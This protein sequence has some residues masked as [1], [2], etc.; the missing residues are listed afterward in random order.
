MCMGKCA[1][2]VRIGTLSTLPRLRQ[3]LDDRRL[4]RV[5]LRKLQQQLGQRRRRKSKAYTDDAISG[6]NSKCMVNT[7]AGI[8]TLE[9]VNNDNAISKGREIP[10]R[11]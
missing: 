5:V 2:S 3:E 4:V 10:W 1:I 9:R 11:G 7:A 8:R 6:V